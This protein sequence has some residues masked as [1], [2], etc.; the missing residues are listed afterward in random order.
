MTS[1][2]CHDFDSMQ[3]SYRPSRLV[4]KSP[5]ILSVLPAE[6]CGQQTPPDAARP[7]L[8]EAE[9]GPKLTLLLLLIDCS[10]TWSVT[11]LESKKQDLSERCLVRM[12]VGN[13]V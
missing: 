8:M 10:R 13:E 9:L 5:W 11:D 1:L 4:G 7:A 12:E 3:K 2:R 6:W